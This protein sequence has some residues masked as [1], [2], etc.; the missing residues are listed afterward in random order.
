[1]LT[2]AGIMRI[3]HLMTLLPI[4]IVT[5]RC[6]AAIERLRHTALLRRIAFVAGIGRH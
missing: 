6:Q 3:Q 4:I 2:G 5:L 1:M